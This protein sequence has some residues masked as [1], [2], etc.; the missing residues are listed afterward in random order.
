[1]AFVNSCVNFLVVILFTFSQL[2]KWPKSENRQLINCRFTILISSVLNKPYTS[3]KNQINRQRA[4]FRILNINISTVFPLTINIFGRLSFVTAEVVVFLYRSCTS[5]DSVSYAF[6]NNII[7]EY[8]MK[9][10]DSE[11]LNCFCW[12]R[13]V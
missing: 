9:V 6:L 5:P 2:L 10:F 4:G 8:F 12:S 13:A 11:G 1:M 7:I 3:N